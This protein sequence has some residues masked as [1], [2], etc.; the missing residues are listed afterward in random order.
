[1]VLIGRALTRL[2]GFLLLAVVSIA[3]AV[4]AVGSLQ[5]SGDLSLPGLAKRV[6]L[7]GLRDQ[8][9]GFLAALEGHGPVALASALGG[10]G[11]VAAGVIL[12]VG[13]LWPRRERLVLLSRGSQGDLSAR[14]RALSQAA[15]ALAEQTQGVRVRRARMRPRRRG[16]GGRL[17][18]RASRAASLSEEE[19]REHTAAALA[20]LTDTFALRA[21]VRSKP[22]GR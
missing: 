6:R 17:R 4:V 13:V 1:M 12:L 22:G 5:S 3:G 20:P 21:S 19:V 2:V 18:L 15:G 11:A 14:R 10:A 7:P 8:V 9:G 16:G